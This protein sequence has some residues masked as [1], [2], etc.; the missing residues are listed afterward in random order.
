MKIYLNKTIAEIKKDFN[1]FF[2]GLSLSFY[3]K[4]HKEREGSS[5]K[6][7][8]SEDMAITNIV[9]FADE[10]YIEINPDM[11]VMEFESNMQEKYKLSI[12]VFRKSK[13]LWLQT[14][15]TDH[16]SLNLQNEKG[17]KSEISN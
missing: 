6:E 17:L 2:P 1:T 8:I 12:Q 13:D 9:D 3:K 10:E 7:E 15:A 16:W 11:S 5:P 14:S 4:P